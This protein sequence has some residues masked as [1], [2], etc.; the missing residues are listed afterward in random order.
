MTVEQRIDVRIP[1]IIIR[2]EHAEQSLHI[3]L[4]AFRF[5][6]NRAHRMLGDGQIMRARISAAIRLHDNRRQRMGHHIM[7][8]TGN[9]R[10]FGQRRDMCLLRFTGHYGSIAFAHGRERGLARTLP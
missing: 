8:I 4:R 3:T 1:G 2:A 7:H 5:M 10:A 9:A 6:A